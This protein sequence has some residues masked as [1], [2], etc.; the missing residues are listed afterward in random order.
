MNALT[1]ATHNT[2]DALP[3]V[4]WAEA[5]EPF[6]NTLDS[7]QT[8]RAYRAAIA[9]AMHGLAVAT[10]DEIAP[11]MLTTYRAGLVAHLDTRGHYKTITSKCGVKIGGLACVFEVLP[12]DRPY[13]LDERID[14][15][16]FSLTIGH[17]R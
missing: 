14:R 10:L 8:R 15:L 7:P 11:A 13:P 5:I 4:T 16:H 6:L 2:I 3:A 17:S 9:E 12:I 1:V